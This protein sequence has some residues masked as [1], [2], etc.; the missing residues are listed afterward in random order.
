MSL[1]AEVE[2][3]EFYINEQEEISL[4]ITLE[5][6]GHKQDSVPLK[7]DNSTVEGIIY[8]TNKQK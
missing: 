1:V 3:G 6:L 5:E 8:R 2:Y 4:I 7:T